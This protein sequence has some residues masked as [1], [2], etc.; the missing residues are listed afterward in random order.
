MQEFETNIT[1]P[2][3]AI[4]S[5]LD[6][7][8]KYKLLTAQEEI[9]LSRRINQGD[10]LARKEFINR[11][12]K[13][14]VKIA[15]KFNHQGLDF[16]DLI[17]E[18]NAGLMVAVERFDPEKGYRFST[19]ATWWIRHYVGRAVDCGGKTIRQ[20]I[21]HRD[22]I[23]K[24]LSFSKSF[25]LALNRKPTKE[26]LGEY[27]KVSKDKLER[28]YNSITYK[29]EDSVSYNTIVGEE[30]ETTLEAFLPSES[31]TFTEAARI[32]LKQH[33][34]NLLGVLTERNKQVLIVKYGLEDG[35]AKTLEQTSKVFG[36]TRERI[37]QIERNSFKKLRAS[38]E[39][40]SVFIPT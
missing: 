24:A 16:L 37:R 9:E 34:N 5:Y 2:K 13:L 15:K 6:S 33:L 23:K 40:E 29:L 20:P 10:E 12:L 4:K 38:K 17:Q 27:L 25:E 39:I 30:E 18:G 32:I 19:Y 3:D 28:V 31:D 1:A 36:L 11:N 26:E 8:A 7:I 21:H 22:T 35:Q 14:V